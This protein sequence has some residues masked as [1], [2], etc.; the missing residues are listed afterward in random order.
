MGEVDNVCIFWMC[1]LRVLRGCQRRKA[2]SKVKAG[3]LTDEA[4]VKEVHTAA[5]GV[6][7]W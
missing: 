7:S 1:L 2:N 6:V 5:D 4:L 3:D